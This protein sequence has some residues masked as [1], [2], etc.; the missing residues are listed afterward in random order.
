MLE[1][2]VLWEQRDFA[3]RL[4]RVDAIPTTNR[5]KNSTYVIWHLFIHIDGKLMLESTSHRD[6]DEQPTPIDIMSEFAT[7]LTKIAMQFVNVG[8]TFG[9]GTTKP[10]I[11]LPPA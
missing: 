10:T 9:T 1:Q 2:R 11:S 7:E 4:W 5:P 6:P 3:N 8:T